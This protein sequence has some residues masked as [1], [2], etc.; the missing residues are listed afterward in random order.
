MWLTLIAH[1][2]TIA[3]SQAVFGDVSDLRHTGPVQTG[4]VHTVPGPIPPPVPRFC[5]PEPACL[6]TMARL[7]AGGSSGR[8]GF[9]VVDDLR[10][11]DFGTWRGRTLHQVAEHDPEGLQAWLHDPRACPHGGE[12]LA[13][14]LQRIG[15]L[16]DNYEWPRQAAV[17]VASAL[18][19]RAA[20]VHALGADAD[21]LQHLDMA[22]WTTVAI[23]WG[24]P[25]WRLRSIV[26]APRPRP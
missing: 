2:P 8:E 24:H 3:T 12:T 15:Q 23:S 25:A 5:G 1:G 6:Q 21:S 16:L 19:V 18:T 11:P 10:G 14:H 22:P 17:I 13:Q 7:T 20:C 26:P 4:A 9:A